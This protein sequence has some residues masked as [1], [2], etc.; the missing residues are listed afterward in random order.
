MMISRLTRLA[1]LVIVLAGCTTPLMG[2][3]RNDVKS[4]ESEVKGLISRVQNGTAVVNR[5]A[6]AE[7]DYVND[8]Y[9]PVKKASE[10]TA[11]SSAKD[12]LKR[13]ISVN[14]D[15]RTIQDIAERITSLTGIPVSVAPDALAPQVQP[16]AQM[17]VAM[18]APSSPPGLSTPLPAPG[19]PY[20]PALGGVGNGMNP[21]AGGI[22]LSYDGA[23]SGLLDIAAARFGVSWEWTGNSIHIFRYMTKTFQIVALPGDSTMQNMITNQTGGTSNGSGTGTTNAGAS[24]SSGVSFS[25]LSVW[26]A[27]KESVSGMLSPNGKVSVTAATGTMTVTDTPQIVDQVAK[28]IDSQNASLSKQVVVNVRVLA[29]DLNDADQYGI[30]W[31][32]MYNSLSGNFGFGLSNAFTVSTDASSL[33]LKVLGTP[34]T[35][36]ASDAGVAAWRGS[37]A[38]ISALSSQGRVSQITSA[39]L[40]TLNNQPAPLQVGRQTSYLASSSTTLTQGVGATTT[41]TPGLITTGFSMSLVPHMLDKGRMVLQFAVNI[42]SLL[43]LTSTSSGGS[44]IQSPDIDTRNFLQRVRINSGETLIMTGFEQN[45]LN[46]TTQGVGSAEN[47]ALGGGMKGSKA[48]S[49]L[50]ILIQPIGEV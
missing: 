35:G 43:N 48:R 10:V 34:G 2:P 47:I 17:P 23:V 6:S 45:V 8:I 27:I 12:A 39:S 24:S 16:G 49:I 41:L 29:V 11:Q 1:G 7:S 38:I 50:V 42:S 36:T 37:K 5:E 26:N 46:A 31:D 18:P 22:N 33:A 44:T 20:N 15:F 28:F 19:V 21:L 3:I 13:R 14:R 9:L 4:N 32:A 25:G 40:T 30:N